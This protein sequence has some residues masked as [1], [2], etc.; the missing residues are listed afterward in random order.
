MRIASFLACVALLATV[1]TQGFAGEKLK[2]DVEKS[3]IEFVGGKPDKTT[4]KGGFKKFTAECEADFEEPSNSTMKIEIKTESLWSD[5]KRLTGHLKNPDFFNVRK[6]PTATF[7]A[8]KISAEDESEVTIAGK[9]K[10]LDKEGEVKAPFKAE[11]SESGLK[12]SGKFKI[13]RTKWGMNYGAPDKINKEV[14]LTVE[15]VFKR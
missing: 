2:L 7:V 11:V 1:S 13:D 14:E 9:L 6:F 8:T 12:L 5:D 10:M 4:H 3:K 15:L